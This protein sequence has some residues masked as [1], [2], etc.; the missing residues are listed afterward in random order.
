[1]PLA[2]LLNLLG[3]A[4]ENVPQGCLFDTGTWPMTKTTYAVIALSS[5]SSLL[6]GVVILIAGRV[7]RSKDGPAVPEGAGE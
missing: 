7:L 3:A 2:L 4:S 5:L 6:A 1:M